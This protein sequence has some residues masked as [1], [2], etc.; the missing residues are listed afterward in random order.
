MGSNYAEVFCLNYKDRTLLFSCGVAIGIT[1]EFNATVTGVFFVIEVI[2][3][4]M[5]VYLL[6]QM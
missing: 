6:L 1:T 3:A 5:R 4:D 2:L